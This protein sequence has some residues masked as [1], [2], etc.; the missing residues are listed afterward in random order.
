MPQEEPVAISKDDPRPWRSPLKPC[1]GPAADDENITAYDRNDALLVT[2][3]TVWTSLA[4]QPPSVRIMDVASMD[5]YVE[6]DESTHQV[7]GQNVQALVAVTKRTVQTAIVEHKYVKDV[8]KFLS[9]TKYRFTIRD[10]FPRYRWHRA[11]HRRCQI[12]VLRKVEDTA[13]DA[14]MDS[15]EYVRYILMREIYR[16]SKQAAAEIT[17]AAG[18]PIAS[19]CDLDIVR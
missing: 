2:Y 17:E 14:S 18:G 6:S 8:W 19:A 12:H 9:W 15:D 5:P 11:E 10:G 7:G 3:S 13:M 1:E 4:T 16:E